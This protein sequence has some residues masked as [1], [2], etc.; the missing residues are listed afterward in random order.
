MKRKKRKPTTQ[1]SPNN[2]WILSLALSAILLAILRFVVFDRETSTKNTRRLDEYSAQANTVI[3]SVLKD[4]HI[5]E[6]WISIREDYVNVLIPNHFRFHNFFTDLSDSLHE[7]KINVLNCSEN[8]QAGTI[9][10][11]LAKNDKVIKKILLTRSNTLP[12]I[13]GYAAI[14]IDDFGYAYTNTVKGFIFFPYPISLSIIPGLN[15]TDKI[16][17][18]AEL[19]QKEYL[20]HMP[21][22]P[23]NETINDHGYTILTDQTPG[24]VRLRIRSACSQLVN[25]VGMNNHQGSKA[26]ADSHVMKLV[27]EELKSHGKFFVDSR[28]NSQSVALLVARELDLPA[29]ENDLFLDVED[30]KDYVLSQMEKLADIAVSRGKAIAIGHAKPN[31]L[32]ALKIAIPRLESRGIRFVPISTLILPYHSDSITR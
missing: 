21:M 20:I 2:V 6:E 31:T 28:T 29:A 26:T 19:A 17:K 14:I 11:E 30:D 25:A 22:E 24:I 23:L 5:Q 15:A 3:T 18:Q 27:L 9:Q 7:H 8:M 12:N 13:A 4:Y 16:K 10:V 1:T 32:K